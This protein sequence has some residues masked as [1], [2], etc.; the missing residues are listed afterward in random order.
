MSKSA[1][2]IKSELEAQLKDLQKR[3]EEFE[4]QYVQMRMPRNR[5]VL[6]RDPDAISSLS[7]KIKNVSNA[8]IN[9]YDAISQLEKS[10][11]EQT[12]VSTVTIHVD[13]PDE[14]HMDEIRNAPSIPLDSPKAIERKEDNAILT[15]ANE[16]EALGYQPLPHT[17]L[18]E[19]DVTSLLKPMPM[20]KHFEENEKKIIIEQIN[21]KFST[22]YFLN[23]ITSNPRKLDYLD[24]VLT[25]DALKNLGL[26]ERVNAL[27]T[28]KG[29]ARDALLK[30]ML[31]GNYVFTYEYDIKTANMYAELFKSNFAILRNKM[32]EED[33]QSLLKSFSESGNYLAIIPLAYQEILTHDQVLEPFR[34][35]EVFGHFLP[36][37]V[38]ADPENIKKEFVVKHV[39][40][41]KNVSENKTS[42]EILSIERY[43]I[44]EIKVMK[45]VNGQLTPIRDEGLMGSILIPDNLATAE[46]PTLYVCWKG[47][48]SEATAKL[49]LEVYPGSESYRRGERQILAQIKLAIQSCQLLLSKGKKLNIV[50]AGHSLGG[51]LSQLCFNS[52]QRT[53]ARELA[54]DTELKKH[55]LGLDNAFVQD[56]AKLS[57][58]YQQDISDITLGK[59]A[60]AGMT[61][62]VANSAGV[63]QP[64]Q[65]FSNV[66]AGILADN[67]IT[68]SASYF[69]ASGDPVPLSG[70]GILSN[71]PDNKA[72]VGILHI[73][74]QG[75]SALST[76]VSLLGVGPAAMIFLGTGMAGAAVAVVGTLASFLKVVK[77]STVSHTQS[78]FQNR[79]RSEEDYSLYFSHHINGSVDAIGAA[80][81]KE[82]L[83]SQSLLAN[84]ALRFLSYWNSHELRMDAK[85]VLKAKHLY[86]LVNE[87]NA[88][89]NISDKAQAVLELL[90]NELN[91]K[92]DGY[93]ERIFCFLIANPSTDFVSMFN[94]TGNS[95]LSHAINNAEY[96]FASDLLT[97]SHKKNDKYRIDL[98]AANH[99]GDT[100]FLTCL[101][102]INEYVYTDPTL[103]PVLAIRLLDSG[104]DLSLNNQAVDAR[105]ILNGRNNF[106][107]GLLRSFFTELDKR[108]QAL[109][110]PGMENPSPTVI[111]STLSPS[112]RFKVYLQT[113][114][115]PKSNKKMQASHEAC[116]MLAAGVCATEALKITEE[117]VLNWKYE[118]SSLWSTANP[119][120]EMMQIMEY[121]NEKVFYEYLDSAFNKDKDTPE[122]M[123]DFALAQNMITK[124]QV[125]PAQALKIINKLDKKIDFPNGLMNI[126]EQ[127]KER[128]KVEFDKYVHEGIHVPTNANNAFMLAE[129]MVM[130]EELSPVDALEALE[131]IK[132]TWLELNTSSK[133]TAPTLPKAL[134]DLEGNI[135]IMQQKEIEERQKASSRKAE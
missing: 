10:E 13:E 128:F 80:K 68:Q 86:N 27:L 118:N 89:V 39:V 125:L 51:A 124:G 35:A 98:N 116:K 9:I 84:W 32:T 112:S 37:E 122:Q 66:L 4:S 7:Q 133:D 79:D 104:V 2:N 25:E 88:N 72:K 134:S 11:Q 49:D 38:A 62:A 23:S 5:S 50:V 100:P 43:A 129:T 1:D 131:K 132:K 90:M 26:N 76:A 46:V 47:T 103:E 108:L 59:D 92:T 135:I 15:V 58:E 29:E 119:P 42:T 106:G 117:V 12:P 111:L 81:I 114:L 3:K 101:K 87:V 52:I 99:S 55:V 93:Q 28:S 64:V 24:N 67:G 71:V 70:Q 30:L 126:R 96:E 14:K 8:I 113:V 121:I 6:D 18:Y 56:E 19:K 102:K 33:A 16:L 123:K 57:E 127:L 78:H 110:N 60:I 61:L 36:Y 109:E 54:T 22:S 130:R 105:K 48:D 65:D 115:D 69:T 40:K 77:D 31:Y 75:L 34:T 94:A 63:S 97:F 95:L 120:A 74:Y 73:N 44:T 20:L 45:T 83:S 107:M 82:L 21:S 17:I 53:L 91:T 85:K 41:E